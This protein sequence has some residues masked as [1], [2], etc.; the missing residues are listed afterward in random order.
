MYTCTY[1][2]FICDG[3]KKAEWAADAESCFF[4]AT[5]LSLR[6]ESVD[7]SV[8]SDWRKNQSLIFF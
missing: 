4:T 6:S 7:Q 5:N 3:R 8:N 2:L 1:F